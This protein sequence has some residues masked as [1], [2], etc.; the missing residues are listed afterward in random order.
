MNLHH[1]YIGLFAV[2]SCTGWIAMFAAKKSG[3]LWL[4]NCFGLIYHIALAPVV[5]A[6]PA[7]EFVRMAGYVWIF[8]DAL[9]DVS[10]INSMGERDVWALRMGVHI[11]ASIWIIGSSLQMP[12]ATLAVGV[13]LGGL[14]ALHAIL[15]PLLSNSKMKLFIFVLPG[16]TAWLC[17]IALNAR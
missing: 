17:L 11:P 12:A 3:N 6:L 9:I 10:S 13:T 16:M 14:L 1:S 5:Q 8:C 7:P 4:G 2:L 15:G